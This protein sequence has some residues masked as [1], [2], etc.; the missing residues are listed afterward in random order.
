MR[1]FLV[2]YTTM[3]DG[4]SVGIAEAVRSYH[5]LS[6][7]QTVLP[8]PAIDSGEPLARDTM[9]FPTDDIFA[10]CGPHKIP[11]VPSQL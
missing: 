9:R 2:K 5:Q 10:L 6:R 7:G 3:D 11:N 8:L 4:D 1:G